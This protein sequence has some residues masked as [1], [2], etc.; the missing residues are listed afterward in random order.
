M[1]EETQKK[2]SD[3][4]TIKKD[5]LWKYSTFVLLAILVIGAIFV[6]AGGGDSGGS[7]NG[8]A[9]AGT[10]DAPTLPPVQANLE[11]E[12][13]DRVKGDPDAPVKIFEFSDFQCPFCARAAEQT[14]P[15]IEQAYIDSGEVALIY[16]HFPLD[17]IHP[18]ARPS[19][20]ASEC[21]G[22]QGK[23][24]EYHDLLFENQQTLGR[25]N[26]I[27]WAGELGLD[28][29]EFTTC[30]DSGK[31]DDKVSSD[32]S[33]GSASGVRG[34]PGFVVNG[35]LVSGAQPFSVFDQIIQSELA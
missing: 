18:E 20:V 12:E 29:G 6:F 21:A 28:T 8:N 5:N 23:F 15:S 33:Q 27:V 7:M 34:T 26:Y 35:R 10:H 9:V 13:G 11:I 31:F 22:D 17:S 2:S 3:V 25:S 24:W 16:K 30:L 32:F 14:I 4:I 19:A 1:E